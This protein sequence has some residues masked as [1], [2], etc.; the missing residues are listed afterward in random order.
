MQ[1]DQREVSLGEELDR[2][3]AEE[4]GRPAVI[5][6]EQV[7]TRGELARRSNR[8]A[9]A[10]AHAGV[11]QGS[12]V[13]IGL[14]NGAA[15]YE[16]VVAAWKLGAVPQPVSYRLPP[17]ELAALIDIADPALVVGLDP[18]QARPWWPAG[19]EPDAGIDDGPL[20]PAIPPSWKAPTSGGSTG[21]PK[22]IVSTA[23]G[24]VDKVVV[25][26]PALRLERD[27][28][29]L[30]TGPLYHNG[31][32][33][34]S[35]LALLLGGTVVVMGRFDAS[36][37]LELVER[38]RVTYMYLVPTMMSRI[39]RLPEAERLGRDMSSLRVAYH[40]AAPCPP[41]VKQAW[42]DWLGPER[43]WELYAGTEAQ[44]ATVISGT[45]W[46]AHPGS[47]GRPV[48]G[49]MRI[50]DVTGTPL[51][52][53]EV[54]D[55]WMRTASGKPSYRY[56]GASATEHDGWETLGDVG[57]MDEDGYLYLA[58]RRS[59]MILVGGAN[60]YPAEIEAAL[61]EHPSVTSACVIGLP[62]DDYGN[63]V[64]AIL[65]LSEPV[66]DEDL[67]A[68]LAVSVAPYKIPRTFERSDVP[69]RDD[70]GKVR[71]GA[72]RAERLPAT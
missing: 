12:M 20:P 72:L 62:D 31:P 53:G 66:S 3:A 9:R 40:L 21:R 6:G 68:H 22:L 13:T 70:A 55:V 28:T 64:H 43:I 26:A 59:D 4:P 50:C 45:E 23:A 38:H 58:D 2:L 17:A 29:F 54:G 61:L 67:R 65:E 47:V 19:Q 11:T 33:M 24:T 34:Y 44:S 56:V 48:F 39:L 41:H 25:S 5:A 14:P 60:V 15:F 8:L 57:W 69:L 30:C 16:A 51:P 35:L 42:I 27:D 37:S 1:E 52:P 18:G 71:R 49:E 36:A 63:V 7:L 46:L 32:F 10:F